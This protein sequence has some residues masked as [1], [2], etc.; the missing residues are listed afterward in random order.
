MSL[1]QQFGTAGVEGVKERRLEATFLSQLLTYLLATIRPKA[2]KEMSEFCCS[3]S[4][5]NT[6]QVVDWKEFFLETIFWHTLFFIYV[7]HLSSHRPLS[8]FH[9]LTV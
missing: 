8:M 1:Q 7:Q 9:C 2:L 4:F 3:G 6:H 5:A